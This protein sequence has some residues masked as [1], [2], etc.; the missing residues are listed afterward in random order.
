MKIV[1]R[2]NEQETLRQQVESDK[3]EFVA[4]YGRRRVGKTFLIK[5]FFSNSF[6]FYHT[7]VA[8]VGTQEQL[9]NFNTSLNEYGKIRYPLADS[10]FEAFRHLAHLLQNSSRKDKKVVF[11]D[12]LPWMDTPRSRFIS[13]LE[14]FW[15]AWA[16]SRPDILLIVCGSA[17]SW[18]INKLIKN[19]GG[20]HNRVTR[21]MFIEPFTLGECEEF[22]AHKKITMNRRQIVESYMMLGGI[23]Y[24]LSLMDRSLSL[25]QNIDTLC[26]TTSGALWEEFSNLYA[27]LFR[28][29]EH[30]VKVVEVLGKKA[31]GLTRAEIITGAKLPDG[32]T[33]SKTLEELEQCGFIRKYRAFDK[34]SKHTL[35]QLVDFYTLFYLNFIRQHRNSGKDFW[36][37]IGGQAKHAVWRGYAFE[38]VCLSHVR[39]IKH[40][41]GISGVHTNVASWRSN[42]STPGAQV[43][44]LIER[45]DQVVNLCEIKYATTEFTIDRKYD[46]MLRNKQE[47]FVRETKTRKTIHLTMITTY[48]IKRN[49]YSGLVH[50][51]VKMD[52]LFRKV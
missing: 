24:Y 9:A 44:L 16:S 43:D 12:E 1:G 19:H 39:Q 40:K 3:P 48:G 5:E 27:S 25:T 31:M 15:N 32:G 33:L 50:S 20:L 51:E 46:E 11:L 2:E 4:V 21:Q 17:T 45:N 34:R 22:Y 47:A 14:H 18:M 29:S 10:W 26:F 49:E 8:N 13:A 38:M 36:T 30:H 52:D 42:G 35:Y 41:L 7:G 28:Y 23:P 37:S 6:T